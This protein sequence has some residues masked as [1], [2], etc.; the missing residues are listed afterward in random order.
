M[1]ARFTVVVV[2][3]AVRTRAPRLLCLTKFVVGGIVE[4]RIVTLPPSSYGRFRTATIYNIYII[5]TR[6]YCFF[7]ILRV[8]TF[9]PFRKYVIVDKHVFFS[10]PISINHTACLHT[11]AHTR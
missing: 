8:G 6:E 5:I 9:R 4:T 10:F 7:L 11:H 3:V 1:V 2:A